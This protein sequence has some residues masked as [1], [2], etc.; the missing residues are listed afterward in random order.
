[1]VGKAWGGFGA[2]SF[3]NFAASRL[4]VSK[5]VWVRIPFEFG[6]LMGS[7]APAAHR[8][9]GLLTKKVFRC[10]VGMA[11]MDGGGLLPPKNRG[12]TKPLRGGS[13]KRV[14]AVRAW[15]TLLRFLF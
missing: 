12:W 5:S 11:C 14:E 4:R 15:Y 10:V 8:W 1:M 6:P 7:V 3:Q 2:A 13:G 9:G